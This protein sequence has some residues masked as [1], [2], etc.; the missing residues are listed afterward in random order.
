MAEDDV[1]AVEPVAWD[2]AEEELRAVGVWAR[3]GHREVAS[4]R[5]FR[6]EVLVLELGAVDGLATGAVASREVA[7]LRHEVVDHAVEGRALEVQR[8]SRLAHALLASAEASEVL[9]RLRHDV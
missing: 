8:L 3:V 4:L 1:L 9:G 5:V 6:G 7:A 2:E